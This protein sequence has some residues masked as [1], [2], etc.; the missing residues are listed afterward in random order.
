MKRPPTPFLVG[1]ASIVAVALLSAL[2]TLGVPPF[3]SI[4]VFL[5]GQVTGFFTLL[6]LGVLGG[7]AVGML[8]AHGI[9]SNRDFTP[10][11]RSVMESL[12]DIRARLDRLEAASGAPH[13]DARGEAPPAA[14]GT[15]P[16]R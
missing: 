10:F 11:E 8:V 9:L 4:Q 14:P 7:A 15:P 5:I 1:L 13:E 3:D 12:A 16:R 6:V 2:V